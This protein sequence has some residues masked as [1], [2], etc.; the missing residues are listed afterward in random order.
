M[1]A[2]GLEYWLLTG[3]GFKWLDMVSN[4]VRKEKEAEGLGG[5]RKKDEEKGIEAEGRWLENGLVKGKQRGRKWLMNSNG[6][7]KMVKCE[8]GWRSE[9]KKVVSQIG[10]M[11]EVGEV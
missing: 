11:E 7:G 8:E 9:G 2:K 5:G 1:T 10:M 4:R 6:Q 3:F